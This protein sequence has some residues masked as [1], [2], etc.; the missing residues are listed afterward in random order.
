MGRGAFGTVYLAKQQGT[1]KLFAVKETFQDSRYKNREAS[2][3]KLVCKHPAIISVHQMFYTNKK[4]GKYLNIV[5]EYLPGSLYDVIH[6]HSLQNINISELDIA[7]YTFQLIRACSYLWRLNIC[8]RDIKPQN[9]VV[10][11]TTK[12]IRL[13]DFGSA[14]KLKDGEWNKQLYLF[15]IL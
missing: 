1:S 14:K 15:W 3:L 6:Q 9:I 8:H 4:D 5:M 11:P 12:K 2:I 13:C 10:D 7:F